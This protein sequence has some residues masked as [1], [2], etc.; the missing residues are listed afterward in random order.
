MKVIIIGGRGTPTLI[1]EQMTEAHDEFGMDVEVL[2]LA[3]DDHSG[4]DSVNGYPILCG[5]R[6]L[7][8]K[9]GHYQD[10][11]YVYSLYREDLIH[12]RSELLYSLNF[13]L[14]KF[15]NFIHPLA[16][17]SKKA[18]M[19][20]GN[21]IMMNSI[22]QMNVTLGNF[23]TVL[24]SSI[25]HDSDLGNNNF[26]AGRCTMGGCCS[27]G[28]ENFFGLG[29]IIPSETKIGSHNFIGAGCCVMRKLKDGRMLYHKGTKIHP[30]SVDELQIEMFDARR[31]E[32]KKIVAADL[33]KKKHQQ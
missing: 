8:E 14:E 25:G 6:E 29:T 26:F 16:R 5:I 7:H 24:G 28:S 13:P 4:G 21:I 10:V 31:A 22:V 9:Y 32:S 2:G 20:L 11:Y 3:L 1:A 27:I 17:V 33:E 19:G 15:C 18:K 23:N 12:E 30:M